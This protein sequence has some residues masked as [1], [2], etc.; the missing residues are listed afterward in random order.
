MLNDDIYKTEMLADD[1]IANVM[2][3]K[4]LL[5]EGKVEECLVILEQLESSMQITLAMSELYDLSMVN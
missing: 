5:Q 2:L 3:L 1:Y 4:Q